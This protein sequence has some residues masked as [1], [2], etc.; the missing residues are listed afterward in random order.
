MSSF[1]AEDADVYEFGE[2]G[3]DL[4]AER[5]LADTLTETL[6]NRGYADVVVVESA[7]PVLRAIE[8]FRRG[9][10]RAPIVLVVT[11]S[12]VAPEIRR[13]GFVLRPMDNKLEVD[14]REIVLQRAE[15]DLLHALMSHAGRI[16]TFGALKEKILRPARSARGSL[17]VHIR[18]LRQKIEPEP[19]RPRHIVTVRARGYRFQP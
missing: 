18:Y 2:L 14:G 5:S 10:T 15:A 19:S 7:L 17:A 3:F 11:Q 16:V 9:Q 4:P 12:S 1:G 6:S 8:R 13:G